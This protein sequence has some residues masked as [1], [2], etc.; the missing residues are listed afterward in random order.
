MSLNDSAIPLLRT[1]KAALV[2]AL[3]FAAICVALIRVGF[4]SFLFLVPLGVCAVVYGSFTA[5]T[6]S[7]LAVMG[8]SIWLA[9]L[10][11]SYEGSGIGLLDVLVFSVM[12]LGFTWIMVGNPAA[13]PPI[14]TVF[15]F[16]A[17][18]VAGALAFLAV[19]FSLGSNEGFSVLLR[20][21]I[22]AISAAY[23]DSSGIDAAQR[24]LIER[25]LSPDR[26]IEMFSLI[27]LRGGALVSMIFL[28]F[29]SRQTAFI[30]ARLFRRQAG[31]ISSDL[32]G[33][34]APRKTI[35]VLSLC[36]P[37]IL[38]CRIPSLRV[39]EIIAWNLLVICAIM[40]L[41]QGGGIVLFNLAR[42]PMHLI[43]RLLYGIVFVF[44]I[45]SPGLNVLA[46][47]IV[48]LLGIA[49]NWLPM[50]TIKENPIS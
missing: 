39:I 13:F 42:R 43:M 46:L 29:F 31:G 37:V 17:A 45:F 5:W 34:F 19:V 10:S 33:F 15:R 2:P 47:G 36:L 35:W 20:S 16:I 9:G 32:I 8:N 22:E 1:G 18:S 27:I 12:V 49:E 28:F 11:L 3:I 23:I 44:I 38:L 6:A 30:L 26:I 25:Q 21:Q 41:A 14:R 48:V 40:F 4:L 7:V 50:R 24:A